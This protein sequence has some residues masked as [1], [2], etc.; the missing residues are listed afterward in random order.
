MKLSQRILNMTP[1]AT[2]A[3]TAL[4]AD[5]KAQGR[6]IISLSIGEPDFFTPDVIG[7]SAKKAID[8]HFT[9]YTAEG[10]IMDLKKAVAGYTHRLYGVNAGPENVTITNGG[11][12]ALF[13][14]FMTLLNPGDEIIVPTPYWVSYPTMAEFAGAKPLFVKTT[15]QGNFKVTPEMLDAA[16]TPATRM[17]VLNSPSNPSGACYTAAEVEAL[18]K[19]AQ[20][21]DVIIV[22]DE[23][24]EQL[25]YAPAVMASFS[26]WWEQDKEHFIITSGVSK[27]YSMTGWRVGHI[28]AD[29][30]VIKALGGF[31]GQTT[32]NVCSI[33]QKAAQAAFN[34]DFSLVAQMREAFQRR[35]DLAME[36]IK[37]WENVECPTPAGAFYIFP[38]VHKLYGSR[39]ADST[40]L[41][42]ELLD[43]A[44][45]ALVPGVAFGDDNCIRMSYAVSDEA[46][47][48]ALERIGGYLYG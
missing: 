30:K 27:S 39:F 9:R 2:L 36:Y 45:V 4:A 12:Q 20:N 15:T 25:V 16:K 21:N 7:D 44:G 38:D 5:L 41:C 24:Y 34:S 37:T 31:Q 1:S 43:K 11:K 35:R 32:S 17:L 22:S 19:W 23:I 10:G 26:P 29:A 13:N 42:K 8:D 47:K 18:A 6:D 46:L 28:L 33:A 14:I 48:T 3:I 40:A